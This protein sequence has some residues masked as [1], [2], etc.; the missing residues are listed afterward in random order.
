MT[1]AARELR[2]EDG[3]AVRSLREAAG[4][5]LPD[6]SQWR[7]LHAGNPARAD[8]PDAPLGWVLHE[9]DRIV[10]CFLNLPMRWWFRGR[11]LRVAATS[12]WIVLPEHRS[13][14]IHLMTRYFSQR[15]TDLLLNAS[16]NPSSSKAFEAFRGRAVPGG[17]TSLLA[18]VVHP[19]AALD[20]LRIPGALKS[21]GVHGLRAAERAG[22]SLLRRRACSGV[23]ILDAPDDRFDALFSRVRGA[24]A[25]CVQDRSAATLRWL[26]DGQPGGVRFVVLERAG[27]LVAYAALVRR[28]QHETGM[29]RYRMVDVQAVGDDPETLGR[30]VGATLAFAFDEGIAVVDTYGFHAQKRRALTRY[31]PLHRKLLQWPFYFRAAPELAAALAEADAWDPCPVEGD[32]VVGFFAATRRA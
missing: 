9:G 21:L 10:G 16:A 15:G 18:W 8:W 11:A 30:L 2:L 25:R 24:S 17:T 3:D 14:S 12:G 13:S 29:T 26:F 19:S 32:G 20:A 27:Q 31:L 7:N 1:I 6:E 28:D 5:S 22:R 4:M 23:T